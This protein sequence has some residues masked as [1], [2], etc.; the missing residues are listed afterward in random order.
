MLSTQCTRRLPGNLL[1]T[2]CHTWLNL[3]SAKTGMTF[4]EFFFHVSHSAHRFMTYGQVIIW[5][6]LSFIQSSLLQLMSWGIYQLLQ[7][8][9][10]IQTKMTALLFL[11]CYPSAPTYYTGLPIYAQT[12]ILAIVVYSEGS[13]DSNLA[14]CWCWSNDMP[15]M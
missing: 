14:S 7:L 10:R 15:G 9:S 13:Q 2:C 3:V 5:R 4:K 8:Q 12:S 1:K 11:P 6:L